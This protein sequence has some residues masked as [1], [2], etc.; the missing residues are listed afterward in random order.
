MRK[1][2]YSMAFGISLILNAVPIFLPILVFYTYVRMG[3]TLTTAKAFV[4]ISL[5]GLI[6]WPLV[7]LPGGSIIIFFSASV[8]INIILRIILDPALNY[9]NLAAVS[10]SR[11]RRYLESDELVSYVGNEFSDDGT[12]SGGCT[13]ENHDFT[14]V[15]FIDATLGWIPVTAVSTVGD[16]DVACLEPPSSPEKKTDSLRPPS[17]LLPVSREVVKGA[18]QYTALPSAESESKRDT[19]AGLDNRSVYTLV[20]LN[21]TIRS[22]SLV[23]VVGSYT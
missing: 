19:T 22:G 23:A 10:I 2:G 9:L 4:T 15:Q 11:I 17:P 16:P 7:Q 21:L 14:S 3:N 20:N 8:H 18:Q 6:K 1:S 13:K 12:V 5:F